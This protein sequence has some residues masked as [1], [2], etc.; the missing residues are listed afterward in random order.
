MVFSRLNLVGATVLG[1]A[2]AAGASS[3]SVL[4][5]DCGGPTSRETLSEATVRDSSDSLSLDPVAAVY[6]ERDHDGSYVHQLQIGIEATDAAHFDTIPSALRPHVTGLR[7]ESASGAVMYRVALTDNTSLRY[8]PPVLAMI[9]VNDVDQRVFDGIRL[10]LL[11]ND[12]FAAI[13]TD[14]TVQFPRVPLHVQYSHDWVKQ[15]CQ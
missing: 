9:A 11:G 6:E 1:F 12:V 2:L 5:F 7:I 4:T 3:C 10:S 14:G 13:E 8:G 15:R